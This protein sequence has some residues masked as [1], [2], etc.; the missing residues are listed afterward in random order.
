MT[1][2]DN[3]I[4]TQLHA[5]AKSFRHGLV[6]ILCMLV[7]SCG[8]GG[9]KPTAKLE[10]ILASENRGKQEIAEINAKL[11]ASA[12][13]IP[14]PEDYVIGEGDL[15]QI[16][17]FET[18]ELKTEMRVGA[19]GFVTLPLIGPVELRNLTTRKAEQKIED[20]Y[21]SKYLHDPHVSVFV[22]EQVAG[23]VTVLGAVKK[24]GP[25]PFLTRQTLFDVL[26]SAEGLA[27]KAGHMVQVR[28]PTDDPTRP[29]V[30]IIDVDAIIKEGQAEL[31]IE[32]QRGDV[33][34]VPLAGMVYV[35]GAVRKPGNVPITEA[36]TVQ[37]AI[38]SA[39]GLS[40]TASE[41]NIKLVRT[42]QPGKREVVQMSIS[43]LKDLS[44][45]VH[46][47]EVK[48]RDVVF[49][50]TNT[51]KALMYGLRLNLGAGLFGIGYDPRST[52]P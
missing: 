21:R 44:K 3:L 5:R 37:E 14:N 30:Y 48:D 38:A 27:E 28:R 11:F 25:Y 39:G 43:D 7:L 1:H 24:P 49:V 41:S 9:P 50:E 52:A 51:T 4:V 26:A 47:L 35:D 16:S 12:G 6:V 23:R 31:N 10:D 2:K 18:Q 15:L 22:K 34:Y 45:A 32:I 13:N 40:L 29:N 46:N 17:V 36:M 33:V 19:R 20:L 8:M 42:T